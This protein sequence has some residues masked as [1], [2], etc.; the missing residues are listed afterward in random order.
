MSE[1]SQPN[2]NAPGPGNWNYPGPQA[3]PP[4][5]GYGY[6]GSP[7]GQAAPME[8]PARPREVNLA[9]WLLIATAALGLAALPVTLAFLDSPAYLELVED[10]NRALGLTVSA[11]ELSATVG[12]A[13]ASTV[14][15]GIIGAAVSVVLAFLVRAGFNWARILVTVFAALSLFG[16]LGLFDAGQAAGIL[17][18]VS[19]L[20]TIAAAVLLFL[21][22]S[23]EYFTRK[24]AFRQARKFGG[25]QG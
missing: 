7:Y 3:N 11:D 9:F 10:T 4:Q 17:T 25:Y 18:L 15:G 5:G 12:L 19:I 6:P 2:N 8:E 13:K 22:P 1:P 24:K 20:A 21:K 16:L 14:I 23:N